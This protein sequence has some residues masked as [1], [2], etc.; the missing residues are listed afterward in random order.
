M[1][2]EFIVVAKSLN[3]NS[4]GLYQ[5]VVVAEDGTAYKVHASMYN[6]KEEGE[7]VYQEE[8]GLFRGCEMPIQLEDIPSDVLEEIMNKV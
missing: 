6:V 7:K 1:K 5:M 2:K 4:F 3:T 8:D